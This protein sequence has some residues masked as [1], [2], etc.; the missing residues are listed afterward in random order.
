MEITRQP[1]M[2]QIPHIAAWCPPPQGIVKMNYDAVLDTQQG[3][4]GVGIVARE[5]MGILM[6]AR[7]LVQK[8]KVQAKIAESMA[9]HGAVIFS[10]EVGFMDVIF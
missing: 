2:E 4:V 7:S 10:K 1:S 3:Y 6:G 9:T 5:H 8:F